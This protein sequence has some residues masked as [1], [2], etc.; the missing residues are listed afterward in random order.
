MEQ[1][2]SRDSASTTARGISARPLQR[3]AFQREVVSVRGTSARGNVSARHLSAM[4]CQ[5]EVTSAPGTSAHNNV[6]AKHFHV[7]YCI[8]QYLTHYRTH[9]IS[10]LV[11]TLASGIW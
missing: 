3:K 8:T 9:G 11:C 7:Y 6:S 10:G 1:I 4:Y 2:P 5:R